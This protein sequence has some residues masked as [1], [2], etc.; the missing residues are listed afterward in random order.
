M[1]RLGFRIRTIYRLRKPR[2]FEIAKQKMSF[3]I[4]SLSLIAFV[5]GNMV[6]QHGWYAFWKTVLGKENDA[7]I[8]FVGMVMP[9]ERVPDYG[10]WSSYGGGS[11]PDHTFRQVP[12]SVLIPLP[13]Y[14][15]SALHRTSEGAGLLNLVYSI[16]H[17]GSYATGQDHS[18]SHPG[19]DI[20][21]P[22]GTPVVSIANGVVETEAMISS[23]YGHHVVIRHPNVPDPDHAGQTITIY[24]IYAHLDTILVTQGE[25]VHMG[26]SI[27]TSG[28]T[29]LASGPHLHFQIDRD[30]APFH[31]YWPFNTADMNAARLSFNA[32]I[33]SGLNQSQGDKYTVSPLL[34]VQRFENFKASSVPVITKTTTTTTIASLTNTPLSL[35]ES[36]AARRA[37]R[38]AQAQSRSTLRSASRQPAAVVASAAPPSVV[39]TAS[40]VQ[41][42]QVDAIAPVPSGG[43]SSD[44]DHIRIDHSGT[45]SRT[46]Q[47]VK[48]S[49]LDRNGNLVK[50]PS[51]SGRI[52]L[53]TDFGQAEIRPAELSASDFVNGVATV[54][55]LSRGTKTIILATRGA[56][57]T[58]SAPM[59]Y[60]R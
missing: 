49:A 58:T 26:Q 50:T 31:P 17:M 2:A 38:L 5:A 30:D 44:V 60:E 51:F 40:T 48:I 57:N 16:G 32:A 12:A 7:L 4:A 43:I 55:V 14:D 8:P 20:R 15:P 45:L 28:Q 27:A 3:L 10:A 22:V 11:S 52:Y 19:V 34:L 33:D 25:T 1:K 54:N 47:K 46:W 6:G 36:I 21:V 53:I 42:A 39:S 24:S 56:F 35:S 29:G 9:I 23:G 59:V 13:T 41:T 37:L 18:G